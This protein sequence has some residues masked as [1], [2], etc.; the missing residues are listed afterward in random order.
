MSCQQKKKWIIQE[1]KIKKIASNKTYLASE[2]IG[3]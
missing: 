2:E 1:R 3:N